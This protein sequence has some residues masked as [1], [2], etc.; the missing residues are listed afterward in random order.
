MKSIKKESVTTLLMT[1]SIFIFSIFINRS[2]T[3]DTHALGENLETY[4]KIF[5]DTQGILQP[6]RILLPLL[7]KVL[8]VDIQILNLVFY[9]LFILFIVM[10][11]CSGWLFSHAALIVCF[12]LCKVPDLCF[13]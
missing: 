12:I 10:L 8:S 4:S 5:P 6:H 7:G 1:S 2:I 13:S 3:L 9:F 11:G